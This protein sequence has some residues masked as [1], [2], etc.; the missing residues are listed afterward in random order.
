MPTDFLVD[1][2]SAECFV[3]VDNK[4][5]RGRLRTDYGQ[6]VQGLLDDKTLKLFV[7]CSPSQVAR[8]LQKPSKFSTAVPCSLE[9]VVYGPSDLSEEIGSWFQDY[10]VYLQDPRVCHLDAR[11]CNPHRLSFDE[12]T[13]C[14]LLSEV[15]SKPP[16]LMQLSEVYLKPDLLETLSGNPN[17][18]ETRQ[19][20][21]IISTLKK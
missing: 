15:V 3:A 20:A 19:P 5:V 16:S 2:E 7:V 13:R 17:L 10:D 11:Y 21:G 14:S 9:V 4:H 8:N 6:M 18:E 1:M 12:L